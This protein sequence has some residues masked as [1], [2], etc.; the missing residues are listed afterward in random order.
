MVRKERLYLSVLLCLNLCF[1][2]TVVAQSNSTY[3]ELFPMPE[4]I[5]PNV[6]FW[7]NI[8]ARYS[9]NEVVIHDSEDL[10][11]VYQVVNL[12]SLFRGVDVSHR[13]QWKKIELIKK[14][15]KSTLL[16]LARRRNLNIDSL[17]GE[18]KR[19]ASL[20]GQ[21][22]NAKRLRRAARNVRGQSGLKERFKRGLERSGQYLVSMREIFSEAGLPVELLALPHVESSFNYKAYSKFGAAGMWQFT[23]STGRR[24]MKINYVVDE[25]LDPII[26]T[27]S[28]AKHLGRN[29]RELKSWPLAITAYNHGL[30]GMKRAK[31][32]FGDDI[33]TIVRKYRS[34]SFGFASRNFYSEFLAALHVSLNYRQ[35]FG[36]VKFHTPRQYLVFET[37]DFISV[38]ALLEHVPI[39]VEQFRE[40]NP[41]LRSPV[42]SSKRRIPRYF[43][44]RIPMYEDLDMTQV[45]AKISD[46][47]KYDQQVRPDWHK[48]S[49][50][51]R[52][53]VIARR[54]RVPLYDLMELNNIHNPNLIYVGQNLQIPSGRA[55][56][57]QAPR[58]VARVE[59]AKQFAEATD[60]KP[61][62]KT[63]VLD[64]P[65]SIAVTQPAAERVEV[66]AESAKPKVA[67]V[68][69]S[70]VEPKAFRAD[71]ES[72]KQKLDRVEIREVRTE[73]ASMAEDMAV[74][75]PDHY[76]EVT[77]NM[78]T[79]IVRAPYRAA[80]KRPFRDLALP[81]NGQ[82]RIE[83]DE[84]LGHYADWLGVPTSRLRA[85][86]RLAYD[87]PIRI[88]QTIWLSFEN[89]T[90]EEF[91]R[92]RLEYHQGIEE[93]FYRNFNIEGEN[94]YKIKPGDNIWHL[95]LQVFEMPY[96]L[97]K[98][99]NA[100]RDLLHLRAGDELI[101]PIVEE[102]GATD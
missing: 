84:T 53:S 86:N 101:V 92:R 87:Q 11:I 25:R 64:V 85:I 89:V 18:E 98:K 95:C 37:P 56:K 33:A 2:G 6:E 68:S 48:V 88:E 50:G 82:V 66:A 35:Y 94:T 20:F 52:L 46:K 81:Q 16:S 73:I 27:E 59:E 61:K 65:R 58:L 90:P 100:T 67:D 80:P 49:A 34:R 57:A 74:A 77:R 9:E 93:D 21:G 62:D 26:A 71:H 83:P 70:H 36:E 39:T 47:F 79:R 14:Q 63:T 44:I 3:D 17:T 72:S 31:R 51:E 96:W 24:Y 8:Y 19:V 75:L 91:H 38:K 13:L 22:L 30:N 1:I 28:A 78:S 102:K 60:I 5:E 99:H 15:Y 23:R 12:K 41:A 55:T 76:V 69:L 4:I 29:Y 32:K 54:Y 97:L 40:L 45:Y 42:L 7:K 10:E 43:T